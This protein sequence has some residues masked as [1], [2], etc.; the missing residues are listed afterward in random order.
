MPVL[1]MAGELDAKFLAIC[2]QIAASVPE[3]RFDSIAGTGHAAHLQ[4]PGQVMAVLQCWL[5][6]INW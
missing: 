5:N 3:G 4:D 6:D 1:T 2:R